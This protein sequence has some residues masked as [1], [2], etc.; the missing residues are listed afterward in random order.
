MTVAPELVVLYAVWGV[1]LTAG[2]AARRVVRRRERTSWDRVAAELGMRYSTTDPGSIPNDMAELPFFSG[3]MGVKMAYPRSMLRGGAKIRDVMTGVVD[4]HEVRIFDAEGPIVG[5]SVIAGGYRVAEMPTMADTLSRLWKNSKEE[6]LLTCAAMRLGFALPPLRILPSFFPGGLDH[7]FDRTTIEFEWESF[8]RTYSV[9]GADAT[10]AH[11]LV[12]AR[13]MEALML[14]EGAYAVQF[15]G[16]WLMV[17]GK[18]QPPSTR[19][20]M[21]DTLVRVAHAVPRVARGSLSPH[22]PQ[23][24]DPGADTP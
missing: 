23:V 4:G 2:L 13:M 16:P 6:R 10:L 22:I 3:E 9:H 5:D 7:T 11:A 15:G 18:R 8:N 24:A 21:V 12:D 1:A 14:D 19:T 20:A 17:Y